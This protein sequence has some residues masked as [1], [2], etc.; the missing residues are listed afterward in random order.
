[1][2][3]FSIDG[4]TNYIM[5]N[6]L[7][8]ET[9]DAI[10]LSGNSSTIS[11]NIITSTGTIGMTVNGNNNEISMNS[12][13]ETGQYTGLGS[14]AVTLY[15]NGNRIMNNTISQNGEGA[16]AFQ[17]TNY[18]VS[19]NIVTSNDVGIG[20]NA[21]AS[22]ISNNQ[23]DNN[24]IG[25]ESSGP[26]GEASQGNTIS[27]NAVSGNSAGISLDGYNVNL[28]EVVGNQI[29]DNG[30][31]IDVFSAGINPLSK[32]AITGNK[33]GIQVSSDNCTISLNNLAQNGIAI[34]LI[35][36]K[37]ARVFSNK[38]TDS[39]D[40]GICSNTSNLSYIYDNS[41]NNTV[42]AYDNGY[43]YWN[44]NPKIYVTNILGGSYQGGN[45]WSDY[46][47]TDT[48]NDGFGDVPYAISSSD[49]DYFPLV[50]AVYIPSPT[51][52]VFRQLR[53]QPAH[54]L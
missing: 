10:N 46:N 21:F 20:F 26:S 52:T 34:S 15:G 42:N 13:S 31:G 49:I 7:N 36:G 41:L 11:A 16:L 28:N 14:Q 29:T 4:S 1:M 44:L 48:N 17:G 43:N 47:G 5:G 22:V 30:I 33:V 39:I 25:I 38:I 9:N 6:R 27:Q 2:G 23:V 3:V 45:Y 18:T 53:L 8:G 51:L 35:G 40:S 24:H 37:Y 50:S 19:G 32:N 54:L 12:V